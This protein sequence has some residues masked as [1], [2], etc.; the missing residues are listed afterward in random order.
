LKRHGPSKLIQV[1][2]PHELAA[3]VDQQ[4]RESRRSVSAWVR[5]CLQLTKERKQAEQPLCPCGS[6]KPVDQ[7]KGSAT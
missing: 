5:I 2:L 6:G 4:A 1:V 3:W 7:C